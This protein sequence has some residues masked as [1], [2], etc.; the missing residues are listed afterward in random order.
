M[1]ETITQ[2]KQLRTAGIGGRDMMILVTMERN[3]IDTLITHDKNLLT[4]T[5]FQRV[6][7][8]FS[9]PLILKKGEKLPPDLFKTLRKLNKK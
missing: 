2:L 8:I 3:G 4:Q 5:K 7:P 1:V 6:D 9:P